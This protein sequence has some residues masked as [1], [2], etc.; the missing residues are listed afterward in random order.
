M[1][2]SILSKDQYP[3]WDEYILNSNDC[4]FYH[5]SSW[6]LSIEAAY[7]WRPF[8]IVAR[9]REGTIVAGV[10]CIEIK[11]PFGKYA[12]SVPY[13]T[14]SGI[15]IYDKNQ[16]GKIE[17]YLRNLC[18]EQNWKFIE[19]RDYSVHETKKST[20]VSQV[21]DLQKGQDILWKELSSSERA[22]VRKAERNAITTEEETKYLEEFYS[23]FVDRMHKFGT[24]QHSLMVMDCLLKLA[25]GNTS[26]IVLKHKGNVIGGMF[27]GFT[28]DTMYDPWAVCDL[29]FNQFSPN[30]FLY[31]KA[32]EWGC[33]N[34]LNCFDMGRSVRGSGVY[35][36]KK[37]WG[38]IERPLCYRRIMQNGKETELTEHA[39]E[40]KVGIIFSDIWKK[41]PRGLVRWFG[42]YVR[43]YIP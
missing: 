24:P 32:I 42:P 5:L 2:I 27:I 31:W 10:Q 7:G 39:A 41:L 3:L 35:R 6:G 18:K 40:S 17:N 28:D 30:D 12:C 13:G 33:Q 36:F 15:I 11:I 29:R 38:A 4:S 8:I 14:N 37:K 20:M 1:D 43:R 23:I 26:L 19:L 34:K 21:L 9:N 16:L 25:K 22:C